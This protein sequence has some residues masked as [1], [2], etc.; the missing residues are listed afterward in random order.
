MHW[1]RPCSLH[2]CLP[3]WRVGINRWRI[4]TAIRCSPQPRVI[5]SI[6]APPSAR[7]THVPRTVT[8]RGIISSSCIRTAAPST[9]AA[10]VQHIDGS[11]GN[12]LPSCSRVPARRVRM[13]TCCQAMRGKSDSSSSSGTTP[14][15]VAATVPA[16]ATPARAARALASMQRLEIPWDQ[17]PD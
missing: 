5:R 15:T 3:Q 13:R 8:A 9:A 6:N 12:I 2:H 17:C 1:P 10:N 16:R 14:A 7:T 11:K 4:H